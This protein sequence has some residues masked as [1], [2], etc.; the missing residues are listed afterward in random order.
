M[1]GSEIVVRELFV[2]LGLRG[3]ISATEPWYPTGN[4][5]KAPSIAQLTQQNTIKHFGELFVALL[6][7]LVKPLATEKL[8]SGF[9]GKELDD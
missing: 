7:I 6:R 8:S 1:F 9:P 4:R 2:A 5:S 3:G